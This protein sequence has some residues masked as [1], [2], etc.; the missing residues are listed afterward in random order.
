MELCIKMIS[1][2]KRRL[3]VDSFLIEH[4]YREFNASADA[5]ANEALDTSDP[6]RHSTN[7]VVNRGR[8]T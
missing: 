6:A 7:V 5:L 3:G 4:V 2:L 8:F 1:V